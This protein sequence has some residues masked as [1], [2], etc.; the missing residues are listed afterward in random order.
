MGLM[1]VPRRSYRRRGALPS[2]ATPSTIISWPFARSHRRRF[3]PPASLWTSR[4]ETSCSGDALISS[5]QFMIV[6]SRQLAS[7]PRLPAASSRP[8]AAVAASWASALPSPGLAW[9]LSAILVFFLASTDASDPS[10]WNGRRK[11][12]HQLLPAGA[13]T[14]QLG[15]HLSKRPS[16]CP[17]H[18]SWPGLTVA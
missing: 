14:A 10:L 17:A 16:Q 7:S 4:D 5:C 8:A 6:P 15:H 13:A 2:L 11:R 18:C 3:S 9:R 1:V 12:S